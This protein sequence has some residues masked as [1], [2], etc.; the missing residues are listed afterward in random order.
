MNAEYMSF[1]SS[2]DDSTESVL[3][4]A[5]ESVFELV[6]ESEFELVFEFELELL[7]M[8]TLCSFSADGSVSERCFLHVQSAFM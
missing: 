6:F 7:Y 2:D 3:E 4:S 8:S 5:L 1:V